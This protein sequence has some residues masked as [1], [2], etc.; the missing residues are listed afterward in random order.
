MDQLSVQE[1][2]RT[3]ENENSSEDKESDSL[4][5]EEFPDF[6]NYLPNPSY[7]PEALQNIPIEQDQPEK[8]QD[9][10]TQVT[11]TLAV[12]KPSVPEPS[13]SSAQGPLPLVIRSQPCPTQDDSDSSSTWIEDDSEGQDA[14]RRRE[15][16]YVVPEHIQRRIRG[17]VHPLVAELLLSS[18]VRFDFQ[19]IQLIKPTS[20]LRIEEIQES[21][22]EEAPVHAPEA[23]DGSE[24]LEAPDAP[25]ASNDVDK[26]VMDIDSKCASDPSPRGLNEGDDNNDP[27]GN[28]TPPPADATRQ[29]NSGDSSNSSSY[30]RS[31]DRNDANQEANHDQ[32][33]DESEDS[34]KNDD[35]EIVDQNE[36]REVEEQDTNALTMRLNIGRTRRMKKRARATKKKLPMLPKVEVD[37]PPPPSSS[38]SPQPHTLGKQIHTSSEKPHNSPPVLSP[39]NSIFN[40]S[41]ARSSKS[42]L[43]TAPARFTKVTNWK[44]MQRFQYELHM[45]QESLMEQRDARHYELIEGLSMQVAFLREELARRGPN[46]GL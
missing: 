13:S 36:S 23:L 10:L 40:E 12:V 22:T 25:S 38:T 33:H 39:S 7:T 19:P 42:P 9:I 8:H 26:T 31:D 2:T 32:S 6:S 1:N 44:T 4:K 11:P 14:G 3:N 45:E 15:P 24:A 35:T 46:A 34:P 5:E 27:S 28:P 18:I 29:E 43:P 17:K 21:I 20:T 16:Y 41:M 37:L 30:S